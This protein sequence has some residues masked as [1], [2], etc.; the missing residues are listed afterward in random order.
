MGLMQALQAFGKLGRLKPEDPDVPKH[1]AR[2]YH[3]LGES[4]AAI[5]VRPHA[6][7]WSAADAASKD[8]DAVVIAV[9]RACFVC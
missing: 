4:A 8:A 2:L 6:V 5:Q 1:V 9:C 3:R 7:A